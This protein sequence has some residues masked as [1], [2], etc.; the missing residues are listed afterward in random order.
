MALSLEELNEYT[1]KCVAPTFE[2]LIRDY[3]NGYEI[4][5]ARYGLRSIEDIVADRG[6]KDG[7]IFE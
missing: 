5:A 2:N 1:A 6:E 3:F 4:I 7:G